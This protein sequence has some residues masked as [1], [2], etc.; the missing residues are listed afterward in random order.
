M[1]RRRGRGEVGG[2]W[3]GRETLE[4]EA[5]TGEG[6][7][8]EDFVRTALRSMTTDGTKR[9]EGGGHGSPRHSDV[10]AW[11]RVCDFVRVSQAHESVYVIHVSVSFE[12]EK[13]HP[14]RVI[15][16][17]VSRPT[18]RELSQKMQ[19]EMSMPTVRKYKTP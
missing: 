7:R 16:P 19:F 4:D 1:E 17:L 15:V 8:R 3:K 14:L 6:S 18:S 13:T 5:K 12:P 11:Q 9:E 10:L 2:N